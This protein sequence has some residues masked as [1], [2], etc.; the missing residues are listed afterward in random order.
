VIRKVQTYN[1]ELAGIFVTV[2]DTDGTAKH[3][4]VETYAEVLWHERSHA[5]TLKNHLTVKE[6]S[7]G[8]SRV[9]LLRFSNHN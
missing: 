9:D 4:D 3:S 8:D 6:G 5:V 7:L 2:S 1:K